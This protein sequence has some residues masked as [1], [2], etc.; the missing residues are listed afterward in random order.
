MT[1]RSNYRRLLKAAVNEVSGFGPIMAYCVEDALDTDEFEQAL[2]DA[3]WRREFETLMDID[4]IGFSTTHS[5]ARWYGRRRGYSG[6]AI[7]AG[8][9]T[10]F[11]DADASRSGPSRLQRVAELARRTLTLEVFRP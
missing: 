1:G 3:Y 6:G 10:P 8:G 7:E 5:L 4:R 9:R 2:E 11:A